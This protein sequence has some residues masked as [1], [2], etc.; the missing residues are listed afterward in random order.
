MNKKQMQIDICK[1]MLDKN[2]TLC[3]GVLDDGMC[4]VT[5]DGVYAYVFDRNEIVF[6]FSKIRKVNFTEIVSRDKSDI[7]LMPT[8]RYRT[9]GLLHTKLFAELSGEEFNV[10]VDNN[11]IKKFES[12]VFIGKSESSRILA[13]DS[14]GNVCGVFMPAIRPQ[15]VEKEY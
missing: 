7:K 4:A 1:A 12:C 2:R 8:G 10:Y 6:D 15:Q 13:L 9:S 14:F 11:V 5:V 3:A